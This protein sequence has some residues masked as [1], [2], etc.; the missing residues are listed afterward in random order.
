VFTATT[1]E[2]RA[3]NRA[4]SKIVPERVV[5]QQV[6][7]V[8]EQRDELAAEFDIVIA[9]TLVR[10]VPSAMATSAPLAARQATTPVGLRFG[11]QIPSF[12]W[13][14]GAAEL[15]TRLRAIATAA[16]A[17]GFDSL[18]VMDHFRQIPMFGPAWHDM[19]ESYTTLAYLA[20][21]TE[22]AQLGT[23]V[24]GITY[25]N[26]AHLAKIVATLDVLSGG[27]ASCGLGLGW[28]R[29]EHEAYG[30]EFPPVDVRYARFEDA[31]QVLPMLWGKG[32]PP[33]SGNVLQVPDTTCY[34]RPLQEHVP[35]LVGGN[36][37]RRTLRLA[38]QYADACNIIGDIDVVH[39][40][41]AAL[42]AHC[43]ALGRDRAAVAIT[44]L[45][46]TLVGR[47]AGEV[48]R[49]VDGLRPR[50]RA[51]ERYATSVNAGTVAD[52]IGR[53]RGLADAGVETAIVSFPDL[54]EPD[55]I[56][57]FAGVIAAFR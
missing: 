6:R 12:T 14:G 29:A 37:E 19:L 43:D 54:G 35:I 4:R 39:R 45:S 34:P 26:V 44:Q 21:H 22:R 18:W 10:L 9:P 49:L 36:G 24:T 42:H 16:E 8:K 38:A 25:R 28:F 41:I 55:P 27:R 40:K 20:A 23:L 50:R 15:R 31:L 5:A 51:A 1:A 53:F 11:L 52:Q 33:F 17:A 47:D 7:Q 2:C 46:T 32:A 57:R 3:R 13:P 30:W 48:S 56:E